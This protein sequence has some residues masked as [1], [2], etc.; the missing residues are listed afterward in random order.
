V[1]RTHNSIVRWTQAFSK[2]TN[3][4][5]L[6]P[7]GLCYLSDSIF[8]VACG[9]VSIETPASRDCLIGHGQTTFPHLPTLSPKGPRPPYPQIYPCRYRVGPCSLSVPWNLICWAIFVR[10][11]NALLTPQVARSGYLLSICNLLLEPLELLNVKI[12][13]PFLFWLIYCCTLNYFSSI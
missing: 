11:N 12:C 4:G 13:Y 7:T 2:R 3:K 5:C 6:L 1:Q 10:V 8:F 9:H